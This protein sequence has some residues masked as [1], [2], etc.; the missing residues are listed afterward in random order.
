[1]NSNFKAFLYVIPIQRK[2][3]EE[4]IYKGLMSFVLKLRDRRRIKW[5]KKLVV[6]VVA[7]K[8]RNKLKLVYQFYKDSLTPLQNLQNKV[9]IVIIILLYMRILTQDCLIHHQW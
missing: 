2:K 8:K 9:M 7:A 4:G 3:K 1:M 6:V 5:S